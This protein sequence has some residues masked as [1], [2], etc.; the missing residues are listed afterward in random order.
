M[1]AVDYLLIPS[2]YVDGDSPP[3]QIPRRIIC[4]GCPGYAYI[5]SEYSETD[6]EILQHIEIVND[7]VGIYTVPYRCSSA[8][9]GDDCKVLTTQITWGTETCVWCERA[10][11]VRL[12]GPSYALGPGA[13]LCDICDPS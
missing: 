9:G 13:F 1:E 8:Y 5:D 7:E 4:P 10:T 11:A 2:E 3:R 6:E 12:S